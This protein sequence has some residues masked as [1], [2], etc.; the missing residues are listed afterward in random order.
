[1][2]HQQSENAMETKEAET[3]NE[4]EGTDLVTGP[5]TGKEGEGSG[6]FGSNSGSS[7]SSNKKGD[8]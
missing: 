1:M 2:Q 5:Q 8:K 7:D 4:K 6:S 3:K